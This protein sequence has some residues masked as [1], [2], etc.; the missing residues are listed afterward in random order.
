MSTTASDL[1]IIRKCFRAF[2]S[3]ILNP[4]GISQPIQELGRLSAPNKTTNKTNHG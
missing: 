4:T 1:G 3:I 2:Q